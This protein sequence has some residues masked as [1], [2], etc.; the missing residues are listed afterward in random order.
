MWGFV[1]VAYFCDMLIIGLA[2]GAGMVLD[3]RSRGQPQSRSPEEPT[4]VAVPD[5]FLNTTTAVAEPPE[6]AARGR[7]EGGEMAA[8]GRREDGERAARGRREGGARAARGCL[9]DRQTGQ[10]GRFYFCFACETL[11]SI[12]IDF[13][14]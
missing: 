3:N 5:G 10:T 7:R 13:D 1:F 4:A 2:S 8:R 9:T 11:E 6:G 12:S 14:S